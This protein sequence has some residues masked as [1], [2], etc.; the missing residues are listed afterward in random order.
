MSGGRGPRAGTAEVICS[1]LGAFEV[2]SSDVQG[3]EAQLA[4][5]A[6]LARS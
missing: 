3:A 1:G 4:V 2:I 6:A 5:R